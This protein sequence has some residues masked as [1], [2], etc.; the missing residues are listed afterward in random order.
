MWIILKIDNELFKMINTD[1]C[2]CF[3]NVNGELGFEHGN[4]RHVVP[5]TDIAD[6]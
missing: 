3:D 6:V 1:V 2:A 4:Y 5:T